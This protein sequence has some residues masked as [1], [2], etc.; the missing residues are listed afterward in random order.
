MRMGMAIL[1]RQVFFPALIMSVSLETGFYLLRFITNVHVQTGFVFVVFFSTF[2]IIYGFT[3]S[4]LQA[5]QQRLNLNSQ[6]TYAWFHLLRCIQFLLLPIILI[7]LYFGLI[8]SLISIVGVVLFASVALIAL[9]GAL[10]LGAIF[11]R[12]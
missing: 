3:Y 2:W 8:N 12:R 6:R 1:L 7:A 5:L 11:K 9:Y 10:L 4:D